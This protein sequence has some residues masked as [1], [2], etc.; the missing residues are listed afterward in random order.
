MKKKISKKT[1]VAK[2]EEKNPAKQAKQTRK[3]YQNIKCRVCLMIDGYLPEEEVC[4]H[5]GSKM[6][7]ID[8]F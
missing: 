5:C 7:R 1:K 8:T 4:K 3:P 6:F 2:K